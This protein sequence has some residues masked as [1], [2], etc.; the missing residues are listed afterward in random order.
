MAEWIKGNRYLSMEEMQNN[1]KIIYSYLTQKGWS[2]NAICGMLGNMQTE[3]SIN[4]AIWQGLVEGSGGGGGYGL[5]Q[6][7]PWTN[8]TDWADANNYAWDDGYAQLKWID[9]VTVSFGQW[10]STSDYPMS[11][12]EYKTSTESC[13]YLAVVFLRN[14]ERAGVEVMTQ[15][16]AQAELWADYLDGVEID[17]D[18]GGGG[19]GGETETPTT[20]K[21]GL[22]K[23]LLYA[24]A[25]DLY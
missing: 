5:V 1:A 11:F 24:M 7:T 4:P 20:K 17:P 10:I 12:N 6:W 3:S 21:K 16:Q 8:F 9:E 25:T 15:R 23:L 19:T 18:T 22:S 13:S 14:F 2:F